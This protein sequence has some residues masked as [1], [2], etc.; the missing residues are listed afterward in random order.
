MI[1]TDESVYLNYVKDIENK[2]KSL[3]S[4]VSFA[5]MQDTLKQDIEKTRAQIMS[6]VFLIRNLANQK[7]CIIS[8]SDWVQYQKDINALCKQL[9][10]KINNT[11]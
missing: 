2:I 11:R 5:A 6:K 9:S 4:N 3:C 10:D 8:N 7:K 1:V